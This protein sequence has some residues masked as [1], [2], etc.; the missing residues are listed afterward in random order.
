MILQKS[1]RYLIATWVIMLRFFAVAEESSTLTRSNLLHPFIIDLTNI[2]VASHSE[3]TTL[4]RS[5]TRGPATEDRT[6]KTSTDAHRP[7]S[8]IS[9]ITT[10][11]T[12]TNTSIPS[13]SNS[14]TTSLSPGA[15]AGI[16]VGIIVAVALM[17]LAL[18]LF[19][20]R[21][22]DSRKQHLSVIY[23]K[24]IASRI[25]EVE[26]EGM[27]MRGAVPSQYGSDG[28]SNLVADPSSRTSN[29]PGHDQSN[30]VLHASSPVELEAA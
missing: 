1:T 17:A 7:T 18:F 16:V 9:T 26:V 25:G 10:A 4:H 3:Q 30:T 19:I 24:D 27:N 29:D 2:D 13:S 28:R 11:I 6:T 15:I 23:D 8:T 22:R 5:T 20:R 14:G 12:A 21:M